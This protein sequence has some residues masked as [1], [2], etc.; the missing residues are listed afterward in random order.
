MLRGYGE[1]AARRGLGAGVIVH[2]RA[3]AAC[4]TEPAAAQA[5]RSP[6][7]R[8]PYHRLFVGR[9]TDQII[10]GGLDNVIK[11]WD[12]RKLDV[13]LRMEGHGNTVT[14]LR[15]S[16]D[17]NFVL[18]NSMDNTGAL[19]LRPCT[20]TVTFYVFFGRVLQILIAR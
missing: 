3:L 7:I 2:Y 6:C 11:V 16:P 1:C 4:N 8:R 15:L 14:G 9:K 20:A 12:T 18:S 13:A 19:Q 10:T 17:G 5:I